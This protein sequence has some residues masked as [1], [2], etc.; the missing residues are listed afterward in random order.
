MHRQALLTGDAALTA[1]YTDVAAHPGGDVR[2]ED[3]DRPPFEPLVP[4]RLR[5]DA[6]ELAF[7][8]TIA[9][10]GAPA[11]ITLSELAMETFL[12]ADAAT[13]AALHAGS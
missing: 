4:I 1:L 2:A 13:A 11:D 10:F 12:P 5:T 3:A 8:N 7:V 6:G 9:T